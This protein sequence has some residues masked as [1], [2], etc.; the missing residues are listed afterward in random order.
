MTEPSVLQRFIDSLKIR[1][2]RPSVGPK[3]GLYHYEYLEKE[4]PTRF[5]LRIDP[6]G[7]GLLLANAAQAAVLSASGVLMVQGILEGRE[8]HEIFLDVGKT[9]PDVTG[10]EIWTGI[11]EVQ[12]LIA[13]LG[14][15]GD[16][17]PISNLDDPYAATRSRMLAAPLRA[18][19]V[20]SELEQTKRVLQRL[21]DAGIPQAT[22]LVQS[23]TDRETVT[24]IVESA[25]DLGMITG[26]RTLAHWLPADILDE[27]ANAGLDHLT[28]VYISPIPQQHD[29]LT[30][31]GDHDL[32]LRHFARC[33]EVELCPVAQVPLFRDNVDGLDTLIAKLGDR[34]VSNISF[35]ALA[36]PDDDQAARQAGALPGST[37]PQVATTIN[38]A[39]E[40]AQV[41][42]LWEPPVRFDATR[43]LSDHIVAGPRAAGD[44]AI[45]VEADGTVYPARGPRTAAGNILQ[46]DWEQ[47]WR[48]ACF[49]R[50]RE[51]L[52]APTRC[53]DCP[54]LPI[55]AAD[56]PRDG[57]GWSDDTTGGDDS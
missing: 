36:C 30:A 25:E 57:R 50:Y 39:A 24:R 27:A 18:D 21:W 15:P 34:G 17:Y 4:W 2:A 22:I 47:I 29:G 13:D 41:R 8:D 20:P 51:R 43:S 37:L 28:L 44:V 6:D 42:Y 35:F 48:S 53:A 38:E 26:L 45:R 14:T 1:P 46:D 40:N 55:C 19:V 49:A 5:H 33:H 3:S 11:A 16:N 32:A 9:F 12:A 31:A 7:Q 23:E 56:C 10:D 52:A 54:D